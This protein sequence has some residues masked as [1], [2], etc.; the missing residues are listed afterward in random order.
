MCQV[1][2]AMVKFLEK[3]KIV[4]IDIS[5][6]SIEVLQMDKGGVILAYGRLVLEAGIVE[7]GKIIDRDKLTKV[8]RELLRST[9]PNKLQPSADTLEAVLSVPELHSFSHHFELKGSQ[10]GNALENTLLA[11][12]AKVVP[13]HPQE[14]YW[15]Y[16]R[17]PEKLGYDRKATSKEKLDKIFKFVASKTSIITPVLYAA[18]PK[19]IVDEYIRVAHGARLKI[20]AID[21]EIFSLGRALVNSRANAGEDDKIILLADIG[22]Q[23][24]TIGFFDSQ[25]ALYFSASIPIGGNMLSKAIAERLNVSQEEA[26]R[27]KRELGVKTLTS[28]KIFSIIEP[29]LKQLSEELKKLIDFYASKKKKSVRK[30]ILAGGSAS[31]P[32]LGSY[33]KNTLKLEVEVG[34]PLSWVK[35]PT[36]LPGDLPPVL[37]ANAVGLALRAMTSDPASEGMNILPR[38]GYKEVV[39]APMLRSVTD[40]QAR[41]SYQPVQPVAPLPGSVKS[42]RL[43]FAEFFGTFAFALGFLMIALGFLA[44]VVYKYILQGGGITIVTQQK[45]FQQYIPSQ[46]IPHAQPTQRVEEV[47]K[48][49]EENLSTEEELSKQEE[50]AIIKQKISEVVIN[51]TPTGWLNVREGPGTNYSSIGRVTPGK[52]YLVLQETS[53]WLKIKLADDREGWIASQ[54]ATKKE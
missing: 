51:A 50:N 16:V 29:H 9:K 11:E 54:Y 19:E 8:L 23:S 36:V 2:R 13:F 25:G 17:L 42:H 33:L 28:N 31:L 47:Q 5:D 41:P 46:S 53:G 34:N 45:E 4:G 37:F 7:R 3:R 12:A 14:V 39:R 18:A 48:R 24:A 49:E 27:M 32:G 30:L 40:I 43:N 44:I 22:A 26:E 10:K 38:E 20:V 15:D 1:F 6:S 21:S 52:I 35:D